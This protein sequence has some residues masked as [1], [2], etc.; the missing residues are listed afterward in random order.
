[1]QVHE[2][3]LD[4][5]GTNPVADARTLLGVWRLMLR[6]RPSH[7]LAY[8]VKPVVYGLLAARLAGVPH[9]FA[10]ITGL[11]Y[12][13]ADDVGGSPG[14][15]H[16]VVRHLYSASLRGAEVVFFQNPDDQ[17]LF[18]SE[19]ILSPAAPSTVVNGSG[20]DLD[21][22][23]VA[24]LPAGIRFL[25]IARLLAAKGVRE[26]GEAARK[27]REHHPDVECALVG[28]IDDNPDSIDPAELDAWVAEGVIRYL[29]RMSD[30][31]P[32]IAACS[33]YVLPSYSEG[34]PR[35][36]LEAMAVGRAIITTDA[37]GCRETVVDGENGFL[38]PVRSAR[39]LAAA[40]ERLIAEPDLACRMGRRSR[41]IAEDKYDV[42]E[43]NA[44]MLQRM[45]L[46]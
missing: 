20:V 28:W 33:A 22:F 40:M 16:H 25:L 7:V 10:L 24:A 18:R 21:D 34:T 38:V 12:A 9:R 5:T 45:G 1:M 13:F 27:V 15:V 19:G 42:R 39:A 14:H 37:P 31:R 4:R 6:V 41:Q 11:G 29:G 46:L 2:I 23:R 36:I 17:A 32:A 8:T 44:V 43:V 30:V 35:S 26:Y 3:R